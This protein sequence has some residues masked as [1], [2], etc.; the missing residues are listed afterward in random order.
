MF[1]VAPGGADC[2]LTDLLLHSARIPAVVRRTIVP[3]KVE[4]MS[5]IVGVVLAMA[6][7]T[8]AFVPAMHRASHFPRVSGRT[9]PLQCGLRVKIVSVGKTKE[10]WL[11]SA[12]DLYVQ[13]LRGVLEVECVWVR[14]D[15]ALVASVQRSSGE[16][17]IVLDERGRTCNS[18]EFAT[19]LFDGLEAGGSRLTF[20]IGGVHTCSSGTCCSPLALT[21]IYAQTFSLL[22]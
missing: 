4:S 21:L 6:V 9:A 16:M 12:I 2:C 15:A 10:A 11:S 17:A 8:S 19:R 18:V 3:K 13:R 14:D 7:A 22:P 1:S 5:I 20:F